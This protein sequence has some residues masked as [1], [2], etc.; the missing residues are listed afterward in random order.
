MLMLRS[1]CS[2][3]KGTSHLGQHLKDFAARLGIELHTED[4]EQ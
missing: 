1:R 3:E 2:S 4:V